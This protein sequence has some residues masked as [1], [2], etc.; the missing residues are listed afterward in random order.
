MVEWSV[1]ALAHV[2]DRVVMAVPPGFE[3]GRGDR[4]A[5]GGARSESV[6]AAVEAATEAEAYVVHDAARPLVTP[7]LIER[8]VAA[9]ERGWDG[10]VAA[11]RVTDT[12]KEAGRDG[13]VSR[14]LD[15][16]RLWAVQTPQVFR[17]DALRRGLAAGSSA[18]RAATDD[19]SLV[20]AAGG[21]VGL[22]EAPTENLKV[23]RR[24]DLEAAEALLRERAS[25]R[26]PDPPERVVAD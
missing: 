20:E 18:L 7:D 14:T 11:A 19:A 5:G 25:S 8:C 13:R 1:D 10:A 24:I 3:G 26:G 23:T 15:R 4:V 12:V 16:S 6:L 9:L 17:A 22:V 2:C 21:T